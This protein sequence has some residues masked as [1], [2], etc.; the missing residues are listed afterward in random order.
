[1][2]PGGGMIGE[3]EALRR[4]SGEAFR[5]PMQFGPTIAHAVAADALHELLLQRAPG[6]ADFC[7]P[8]A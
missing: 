7:E 4:T 5:R 6:V 8:G 1:M 3:N 2:L